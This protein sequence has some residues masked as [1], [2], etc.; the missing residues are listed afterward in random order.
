MKT[1]VFVTG[2]AGLLGGTAAMVK[3]NEWDLHLGIRHN[4]VSIPG[5][6]THQLKLE[7]YD[8]VLSFL[9]NLRPGW[10]IHA[11]GMTNV[12]SCEVNTYKAHLSNVVTTKNLAR[13][14]HKLSIPF[15]FVSTDQVARDME[16]ATEDDIGMPAN[17]YAKTKLEAE[18]ETLRFHPKAL[19]LR[20]NFFTWGNTSRK[21]FL[22]FI[23]DHLRSG[24]EITL[25]D[26]VKF[27]PLSA[28]LLLGYA[29]ALFRKGSSG[30]FNLTLDE[31]TSKYE[32]GMKVAEIF[33]L[34]AKGVIRGKLKDKS[35]M[36]KRPFNLTLSNEK[37]KRE[38]G[39]VSTPSIKEILEKHKS[40]E[41]EWKKNL[42]PNVTLSASAKSINYG[43]QSLD[44]KDFEAVLTSLDSP[45]LTQGPTVEAFEKKIAEYTGSR[46]A[47]AMTNWTCGLHM[48]VLA[49]GVRPGDYVITSPISFVASSNC[50]IYAG[51]TP[52]FVDIDPVTLNLDPVKLEQA[53]ELLGSKLKAIIPV[54]FA[55]SPCD[56]ESI[57]KIAKRFKVVLIEDAAHAIGGKYLTGEKIGHNRYSQMVG[58]S[59]HPVKNMT[60][61]EG[62]LITTDDEGI[63]RHLL[64]LRS[65]GITKGE[66]P[67]KFPNEGYSEGQKNPWYYEMQEIGFNYRITDIQ[68][69]LG[70][71][72]LGKLDSFL[73][74]KISITKK[75]DEEFRKLKNFKV[76]QAES[77]HLSG[78]HLY[79]GEVNF[80]S[81]KMSKA[82]LFR[83]FKEKSINL[84][85]HYIPI[86]RQ[87][88]Y[89]DK[90]PVKMTDFPA[91][92]N[93]YQGAITL[94]VFPDMNDEEVNRVISSVK[95][96]IG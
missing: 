69:A 37:L 16:M 72:Q 91:A 5:V 22:D 65:H 75:Y 11:A 92:E 14:C 10:V 13:A 83:K 85:L 1:K 87:P 50:A 25:F 93:Y 17:I 95:E 76:L 56:M 46:Y 90:F 62:G 51:A 32:F 78:N 94:P 23:V 84:H 52:F 27:N 3:S 49:A 70:I 86:Y 24:K 35:Q 45:W 20:T 71:S 6:T 63:Y 80:T 42:L 26:D 59:F 79:V 53:C 66:D 61:G 33:K 15:A 67:Y 29:E 47:V 64:R 8:E 96:F 36:V 89:A 18:F 54:H 73:A 57:S 34:D 38:L 21:S 30:I 82:Q 41:D 81:L 74:R 60:T 9:S 12:E 43:R 39:I 44:D 4:E 88:F 58:F 2:G 77:R 19:I 40:C 68:C 48:A 7:N 55:G 31:S 28:E